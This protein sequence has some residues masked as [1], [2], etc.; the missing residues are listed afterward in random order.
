MNRFVVRLSTGAS[1]LVLIA[2]VS[3]PAA[4]ADENVKP[5]NS[6]SE[7]ELK[8]EHLLRASHDYVASRSFEIQQ[9]VEQT[10][11]VLVD[12]KPLRAVRASEQVSII[13]VDADRGLV[14]MTMKDPSGKDLVVIRKGDHIAMK[15]GS[16]PWSVPKG[17]YARIGDQLANPFACPFPKP[18]LEHSPR[19]TIAGDDRLDGQEITVIKTV[20]DSANQFARE[21]MREGIASVFPDASARPTI[22]VMAY[23]S[24]HWIGKADDRRQR[25]EQT[26]HHQMTMPGAATTVVDVVG[27]TTAIYRRYN[28]IDVDVPEGARRLIYPK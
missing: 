18:G 12:G 23:E 16:D 21:R 2:A 15:I 5:K 25:V 4:G 14:R 3:S 1:V 11:R 26:S 19:W 17:P 28:R 20:G 6:L 10:A 22:E 9:T 13:E 24:R 7:A 27:K 8:A